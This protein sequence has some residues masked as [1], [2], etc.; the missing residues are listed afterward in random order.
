MV[1]KVTKWCFTFT[2]EA[3]F[4]ATTETCNELLSLKRLMHEFGFHQ[5]NYVVFL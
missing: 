3:E 2:G 5:Q 4:V 1:I